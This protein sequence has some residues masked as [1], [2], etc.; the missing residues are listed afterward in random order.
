MDFKVEK[1]KLTATIDFDLSAKGILLVKFVATPLLPD[2][3]TKE[4]FQELKRQRLR[5]I[6]RTQMKIKPIIYWLA[7]TKNLSCQKN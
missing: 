2:D 5:K 3:I 6:P 4:P 7:F 1:A